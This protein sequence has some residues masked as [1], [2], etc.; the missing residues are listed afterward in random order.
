VLRTENELEQ[1]AASGYAKRIDGAIQD[2]RQQVRELKDTEGARKEKERTG[3]P[4][5]VMITTMHASKEVCGDCVEGS[6]LH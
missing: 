1:S 6:E 4:Y 5:Q 3:G 2:A